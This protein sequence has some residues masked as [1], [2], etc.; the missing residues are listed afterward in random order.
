MNG[1]R[2]FFGFDLAN[3]EATI[4]SVPIN[5]LAHCLEQS[6]SNTEGSNAGHFSYEVHAICSSW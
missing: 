4:V 6:L 3:I 1:V 5:P 2:R